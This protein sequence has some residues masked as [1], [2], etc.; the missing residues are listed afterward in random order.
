MLY[1]V[2]Y[3]KSTPYERN[4]FVRSEICGSLR[5][6]ELAAESY[7]G[8]VAG[9]RWTIG[10]EVANGPSARIEQLKKFNGYEYHSFVKWVTARGRIV[11]SVGELGWTP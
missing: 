6:A 8:E 7:C 11:P 1:R 3:Y 5:G 9:T 10:R 2:E 4:V